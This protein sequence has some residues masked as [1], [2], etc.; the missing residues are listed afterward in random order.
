MSLGALPGRTSVPFHAGTERQQSPASP[1]VLDEQARVRATLTK[2]SIFRD[3]P[4]AT[5]DD[6]AKRVSVQRTPGGGSVLTPEGDGN[7]LH[8]VMA[9]RVKQVMVGENGREV[10]LT[11]LR[12][13]DIFG[14]LSL[15]EGRGRAAQV[16]AIDPATTLSLPRDEVMR[17]MA[18]H[19]GL[20]L[21]F[22]TEMARRMRRADETIAELALC[23]VQDRLVRRLISL[24]KEDG[25]E[26]P[27]GVLIR[28]R[29]TQQDLANMVGACRETISRTFNQ[30][31]RKGLIIPRGRSLLVTKRLVSPGQP[32]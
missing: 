3:L 10:T 17:L 24:A 26:L 28:R 2:V 1:F 13:G 18:A 7:A 29:P 31:A 5:L 23:D 6:L 4:V 15:F 8:M 32:A 19:P 30:L 27:E 11:V 22:L 9:G 21:A 20:A 16:V 25:M 12:P 14:E